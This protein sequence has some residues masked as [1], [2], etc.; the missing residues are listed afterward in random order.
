[1]PLFVRYAQTGVSP[2]LHHVPA[3]SPPR[4]RARRGVSIAELVVVL[5][6]AGIMLNIALP[7]FAAMR[8]RM[9]LRTAKQ[10]F[11]AL[12]VTARAAAVRQS[13]QSQFHIVNNSAWTTVSQPN[14]TSATVN[15]K[16][17]FFS[18]RSVIVTLGGSAPND[19]IVYDA[20]GLE[21]WPVTQRTYV[22]TLNNLKDSVCVSRVGL[23]AR[24]CGW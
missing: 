16:N 21:V 1:M 19:S 23:I 6:I 9:N 12:L 22:L 20:R 13:Q 11:T 14:G 2:A 8:D 10:E 4:L 15:M 24:T 5:V 18:T 17:R 7:R 3:E